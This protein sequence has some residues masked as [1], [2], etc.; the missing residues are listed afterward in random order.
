MKI[1][2]GTTSENKVKYLNNAL[3]EFNYTNYKL[4]FYDVKSHVS[5]QP[6]SLNETI[7]GSKNRSYNAF[8]HSNANICFGLEG[9]LEFYEDF[10]CYVCTATAFVNNKFI[11]GISSQLQI[12]NQVYQKIRHG[13]DLSDNLN[14][15]I[16][17]S[18]NEEL[19]KNMIL[20][21]EEMFNE[22]LRNC[23]LQIDI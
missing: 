6:L 2:L 22:A 17:N 1:A 14:R 15:Y 23:L 20:S 4:D 3:N 9:G 12:P 19:L 21:R 11:T 18:K 16:T 10:A 8:L 5:E 7:Q 13:D